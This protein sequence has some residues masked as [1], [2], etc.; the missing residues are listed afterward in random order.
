[1]AGGGMS[2]PTKIPH[3]GIDGQANA[4]R[5]R[6]E[7][8]DHIVAGDGVGRVKIPQFAVFERTLGLT[9][10]VGVKTSVRPG[11]SRSSTKAEP[12]GKVKKPADGGRKKSP[13]TRKAPA[14]GRYVDEYA[15]PTS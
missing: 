1:M 13:P 12:D 6:V 15:R 14:R 5:G 9:D 8:V 7:E 11:R 4:A 10:R 3:R 2:Q